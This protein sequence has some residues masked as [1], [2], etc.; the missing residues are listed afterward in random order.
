[1]RR[2]VPR[3]EQVGRGQ[4]CCE[5]ARAGCREEGGEWGWGAVGGQEVGEPGEG[6]EGV[7]G[8]GEGGLELVGDCGHFGG[9]FWG[10]G[11]GDVG[12]FGWIG[13]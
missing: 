10:W 5:E 9:V 4:V 3:L 7:G 6:W 1:M 13:R 8:R 12:C 11:W 2:D